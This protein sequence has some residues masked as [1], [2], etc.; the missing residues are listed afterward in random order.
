MSPKRHAGSQAR[1]SSISVRSLGLCMPAGHR[2]ESHRHDWH[3][4]VFATEGVMTVE[5]PG[6]NWVVPA[7][8]AVWIPADFEHSIRM[9]GQVRMQTLY[10]RPGPNGDLPDACSVIGV[11]A[12]LRELILEAMRLRMLREDSPPQVRLAGVLRDQIVNRDEAPLR[13][14][15]PLD[16]RAR[17]VAARVQADLAATK[18]LGEYARQSGA[19]VRTI[20]RLFRRETGLTFGR[21]LQRVKALHALERLAAG[22]SVTQAGLAIGYESTSAFI[23]MFKRVLGATPGSYMGN[24]M[25]SR[26]TSPANRNP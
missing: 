21:W 15:W 16:P 4:L 11:S 12:L 14:V 19:G 22:E 17:R 2:I 20:E 26:D 9:T 3:Q 1:E 8:R 23:A 13:I 7:Q 18:S 10:F 24:R 6:G 5:T 25:E